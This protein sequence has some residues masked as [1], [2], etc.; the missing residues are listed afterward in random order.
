MSA[1]QSPASAA[2]TMRLAAPS[3]SPLC[4]E[5]DIYSSRLALAGADV[6]ELGCGRAIHTLSIAKA[7]P[8]ARITA[9]EV[10]PVQNKLNAA[11]AAPPNLRFAAGGAEAIAAGDASADVVMMF[12]SLHHV[13]GASLDRALREIRRVLRPGGLA[14][15]SEPVFAGELNEVMRIF[16]DEQ[17][18]RLA[19]FEALR[20]AV[21][22]GVFE[23]AGEIF[24]DVQV[25]YPGFAE[26]EKLTIGATHTAHRLD[27]DRHRRVRER[28]ERSM[29]AEGAVFRSPMRVDLLRR[30]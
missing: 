8:G 23:L 4:A 25:A 15:I 21:A 22:Q 2:A 24:F 17:S 19:A 14:Y 26:F 10:D 16:H 11:L 13:P 5:K 1:V 3:A 30:V 6:I 9:M 18:V 20:R 28:F 7:F 27:A 12:K 29:S